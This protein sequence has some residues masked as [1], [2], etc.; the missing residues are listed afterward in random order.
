MPSTGRVPV[1]LALDASVTRWLRLG[2]WCRPAWTFATA[3]QDGTEQLPPWDE[4]EAGLRIRVGKGNDKYGMVFGNGLFAAAIYGEQLGA[5]LIGVAI[6][7]GLDIRN[8]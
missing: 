5:T 3:R 6:G 4:F 7:H 1:E 8:P 2:T